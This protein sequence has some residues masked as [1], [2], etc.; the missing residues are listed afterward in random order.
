[1]RAFQAL[2][3]PR[4]SEYSAGAGCHMPM[5]AGWRA[6]KREGGRERNR[7]GVQRLVYMECKST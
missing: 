3:V 7:E 5:P 4:H 1:M 2:A 6:G